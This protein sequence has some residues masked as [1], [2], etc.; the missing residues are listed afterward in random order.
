MI[1]CVQRSYP[2]FVVNCDHLLDEILAL[3]THLLWHLEMTLL[4]LSENFG[5]A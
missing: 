5:L 2:C 3:L 4:N 1:D